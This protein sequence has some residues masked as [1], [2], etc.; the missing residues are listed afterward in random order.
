MSRSARLLV[1]LVVLVA[2]VAGA[3]AITRASAR[4]FSTPDEVRLNLF[5]VKAGFVWIYATKT[6]RSGEEV[7][8]FDTGVGADGHAIDALL[9][10]MQAQ[11]SAVRDIFLTHG[12]GD[13]TAG[14]ALF[15]SARLHAGQDDVALIAGHGPEQHGL[16]RI[17]FHLM[18]PEP[19]PARVTHPLAGEFEVPIGDGS[20]TVRAIPV[21]GHTP[22]TYVYLY[23]GVLIVGDTMVYKNGKLDRPPA[24]FDSDR[25]GAA[26]S[27][28]ALI[29]ELDRTPIER[30]CTGHSGCTPPGQTK[31]LLDDLVTRVSG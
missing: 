5:E 9:E 21:P 2:L 24:F 3:F 6:G 29:K 23:N 18:M 13:H 27:L 8:L 26:R 14:A 10:T 31:A 28:L 25:E 22:G 4:Q 15:P 11:R 7:V 1:S 19:T 16:I 12:H 20:Q 17:L 30:L